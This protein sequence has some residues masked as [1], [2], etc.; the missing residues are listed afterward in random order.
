MRVFWEKVGIL[1]PVFRVAGQG[2]RDREIAHRLNLRELNVHGCVAWVL[3]FLRFMDR[4]ELIPC[5]S[6]WT[7][8]EARRSAACS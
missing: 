3:H 1:G 2:F 5:V 8:M 4:I 7:T 6:V